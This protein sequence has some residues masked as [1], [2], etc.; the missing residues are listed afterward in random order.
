MRQRPRTGGDGVAN[1]LSLIIEPSLE[2]G[3]FLDKES[4]GQRTLKKL[5]DTHVIRVGNGGV[6][7]AHIGPDGNGIEHHF[8]A[9]SDD[10]T[11][12][13]VATDVLNGLT[14][15]VPCMGV[16]ELGP[17]ECEQP[18]AAVKSIR[19]RDVEIKQERE[20][21]GLGQNRSDLGS[22]PPEVN[23]TKRAK[24]DHQVSRQKGVSRRIYAE[25]RFSVEKRR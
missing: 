14:Q 3:R 6:E 20:A 17:Q 15:R 8:L 19:P 11:F 2:P 24:L 5:D 9:A 18:I 23:R 25:S 21:L 13:N 4:I 22:I 16:V 1:C 10:R 12:S 7:N